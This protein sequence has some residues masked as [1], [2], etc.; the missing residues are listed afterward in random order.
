VV[1]ANGASGLWST[2][3]ATAKA[4]LWRCAVRQLSR[5]SSSRR[6]TRAAARLRPC[7]SFAQSCPPSTCDASF[8]LPSPLTR[9]STL[10]VL[11]TCASY[12]SDLCSGCDWKS[13]SISSSSC[14][15]WSLYSGSLDTPS[16]SCIVEQCRAHTQCNHTHTSLVEPSQDRKLKYQL[17][18]C[19]ST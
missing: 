14:P 13:S 8:F 7:C 16:L 19:L 18:F 2:Q 3:A 17:G 1:I 5:C 9:S 15:C 12:I 10:F 6:F 4:R 11:P